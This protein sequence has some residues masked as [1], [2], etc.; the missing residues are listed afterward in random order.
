[1][2]AV[3]VVEARRGGLVSNFERWN[4][5]LLQ[6]LNTDSTEWTVFGLVINHPC[7]DRIYSREIDYHAV[8]TRLDE[9]AS[10]IKAE[11]ARLCPPVTPS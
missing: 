4:S 9:Y 6:A 3:V 7:G 2:G 11:F 10:E 5:A 1:M 8:D